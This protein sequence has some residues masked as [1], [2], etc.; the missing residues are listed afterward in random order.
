M[1]RSLVVCPSCLR[2][3]RVSETH[4]PFCAQPVPTDLA[5]RPRGPRRQYVGKGATALALALAAVGCGD[6]VS[7][8]VTPV[9]AAAEA[10]AGPGDVSFDTAVAPDAPADTTASDVA[11]DGAPFPIYK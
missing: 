6:D 3:V 5:P 7:Q 2:H 9:D 4:C 8:V 11:D 10:E 1:A